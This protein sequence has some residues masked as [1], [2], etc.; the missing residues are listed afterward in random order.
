MNSSAQI[1]ELIKLGN[2]SALTTIL[3]ENPELAFGKAD[4]NVSLLQ[5][6]CY[7]R[8]NEA[9]SI[10]KK[11]KTSLTFFEAASTGD[12]GTVKQQLK[13]DPGLINSFSPDGF[14]ALGLASFFGNA[15]IV[16]FLLE[17]N[18]DP[19]I[20]STN[21]FHVAPIHSACAISNFEIVEILIK[22]G[23]DINAQQMSGVT[24]LHSAAHNGQTKIVKLLIE[25]GARINTK[26]TDGKTPL[27]M[28][29]EKDF[30]EATALLKAFGA[31]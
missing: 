11:Y 8:N 22:N 26:T 20:A 25:N 27:A 13:K 28:A 12:L 18:A 30:E 2:N 10:L 9:V 1:I 14:T 29:E 17:N 15:D 31:K 23:A 6:A 19:N 5:F 16:T 21:S 4:E 7:C 24:P 3:A